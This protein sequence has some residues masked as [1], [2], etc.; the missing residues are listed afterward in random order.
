MFT[1]EKEWR[2]AEV[3]LKLERARVLKIELL[4]Q[5][6]AQG[7]DSVDWPKN[8]QAGKALEA[9]RQYFWEE[10]ERAK[11]NIAAFGYGEDDF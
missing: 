4:A 3:Q 11:A 5:D 7:V 10:E 8:S 6:L 1:F 9:L 2:A